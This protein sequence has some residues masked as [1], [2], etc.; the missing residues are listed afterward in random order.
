MGK[1][2]RRRK[3]AVH[4]RQ[5]LFFDQHKNY[6]LKTEVGRQQLQTECYVRFLPTRTR[7]EARD[8]EREMERDGRWRYVGRPSGR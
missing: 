8:M 7:A 4:S 2:C 3:Q 1:S 6:D 5:H